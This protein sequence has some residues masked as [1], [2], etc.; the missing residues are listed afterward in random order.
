[1]YK[2]ATLHRPCHIESRSPLSPFGI[3]GKKLTVDGDDLR[4]SFF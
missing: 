1:M 2:D 4:N 3:I